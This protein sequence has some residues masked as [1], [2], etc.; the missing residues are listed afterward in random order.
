[1]SISLD[2][3]YIKHLACSS[4]MLFTVVCMVHHIGSVPLTECEV[5]GRE[6]CVLLER[7]MV[8]LGTITL[9]FATIDG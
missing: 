9:N 2:N 5:T 3:C 6:W 8:A 4:D 1:M 7:I